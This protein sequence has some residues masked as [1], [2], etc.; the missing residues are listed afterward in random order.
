MTGKDPNGMK[1]LSV[2]ALQFTAIGAAVTMLYALGVF[3]Q[4]KLTQPSE[5]RVMAALRVVEANLAAESSA[6]AAGD[7]LVLS[8]LDALQ[9]RQDEFWRW[10]WGK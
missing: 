5:R 3:L 1:K 10:R 6:R 4:V 8:K 9:R 2:R 7:T